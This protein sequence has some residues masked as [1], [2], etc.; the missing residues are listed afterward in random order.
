MTT[1]ASTL[2]DAEADMRW[3]AWQ[4]RGAESDRRSDTRMRRLTVLIAI[5]LVICFVVQLA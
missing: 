1:H 5:G 2:A 4:A 3:Q